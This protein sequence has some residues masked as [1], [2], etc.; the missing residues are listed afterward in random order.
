M[1]GKRLIPSKT[2]GINLLKSVGDDV[3]GWRC[4]GITI[5]RYH[6]KTGGGKSRFSAAPAPAFS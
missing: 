2:R 5:P 3:S 4:K 1:N 6:Q